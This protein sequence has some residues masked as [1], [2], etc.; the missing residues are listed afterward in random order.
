[1]NPVLVQAI[2]LVA[3]LLSLVAFCF[4]AWALIEVKAVQRS[5][6]KVTFINPT[7]EALEKFTQEQGFSNPLTEEQKEKLRKSS[8]FDDE[9]DNI[10]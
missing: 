9:F 2:V 1:M 5:T 10:N 8:G 7:T 6:H 4:A 3:G